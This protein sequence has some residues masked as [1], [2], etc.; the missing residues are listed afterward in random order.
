MCKL[1]INPIS[2]PN[3][4]YNHS[5]MRQY[6]SLCVYVGYVRIY[7]LFNDVVN[8]SQYETLIEENLA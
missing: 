4:V 3:S 7:R 5:H 1:S 6:V 8:W 2:N